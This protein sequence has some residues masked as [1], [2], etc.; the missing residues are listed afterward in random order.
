MGEC[1]R[2]LLT[3]HEDIELGRCVTKVTGVKC[4]VS[5]EA[6][7]MFYQNYEDGF[8]S[9][10]IRSISDKAIGKRVVNCCLS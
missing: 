8:D 3:A 1:L 4:T 6:K 10:N 2:S 5:W 7:D 9:R